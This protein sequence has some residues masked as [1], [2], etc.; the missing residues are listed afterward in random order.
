MS[1]GFTEDEMRRALGLTAA[2]ACPSTPQAPVPA[3]KVKSEPRVTGSKLKPRSPKLR[4]TLLV[5]K[6]FEGETVEFTHDADTLSQFDAE[7]EAKTLAK[8]EKYRFFEVV[9]I[10]AI[11]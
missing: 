7:Q 8:K 11:G 6:E 9:S 2:H 10:K 1:S 5:S 3:T 4:V